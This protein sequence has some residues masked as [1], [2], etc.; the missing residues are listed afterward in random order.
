M[1]N[2]NTAE[3][4]LETKVH[5]SRQDYQKDVIGLAQMAE[6]VAVT[7]FKEAIKYKRVDNLDRLHL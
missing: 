1:K 6:Q 7:T 3:V 2:Y 4:Y 5:S